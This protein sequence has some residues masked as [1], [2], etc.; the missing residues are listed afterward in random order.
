MCT[1]RL[2]AH[3]NVHASLRIRLSYLSKVSTHKEIFFCLVW[4]GTRGACRAH[5]HSGVCNTADGGPD[6]RYRRLY[7]M[8]T[9]AKHKPK[10]VLRI[11]MHI[12][13]MCMC[14]CM[15]IYREHRTWPHAVAYLHTCRSRSWRR[16]EPRASASSGCRPV[17]P[18]GC[19]PVEPPA[20]T[21]V[22]TA[23]I[24]QSVARIEKRVEKH[25]NGWMLQCRARK[26]VTIH[27]MSSFQCG[28]APL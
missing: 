19:A 1:R 23:A 14:M 11:L 18:T 26:H 4:L 21:C 25:Q 12:Q 5:L 7:F 20:N 17:A 8:R 9:I 28:C 13:G 24:S 2:S 10:E 6:T 27:T 3:S 22:I 16:P 15:C